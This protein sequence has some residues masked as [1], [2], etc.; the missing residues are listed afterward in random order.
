MASTLE[1]NVCIVPE[2]LHCGPNIP[3][4]K[5]CSCFTATLAESK[6]FTK[7]DFTQTYQQLLFDENSQQYTTINT[8]QLPLYQYKKLPFGISSVLQ[9]T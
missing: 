5:L 8:H 7:C 3:L 4:P 2:H 9:K 6:L 1:G